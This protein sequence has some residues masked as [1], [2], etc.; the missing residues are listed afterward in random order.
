MDNMW[1]SRGQIFINYLTEKIVDNTSLAGQDS[2]QK[3]SCKYA[4][5]K[6]Y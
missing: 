3:K 2:G 4:E 6:D 5:I 1:T